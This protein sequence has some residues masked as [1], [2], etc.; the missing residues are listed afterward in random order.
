M[1]TGNMKFY[2][3]WL[4]MLSY[5]PVGSILK[6]YMNKAHKKARSCEESGLSIYLKCIFISEQVPGYAFVLVLKCCH[7]FH[8]QFCKGR[9]WQLQFEKQ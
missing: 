1:Q 2:G 8:L 9:I 7:C 4:K 6:P 3:E 5:F